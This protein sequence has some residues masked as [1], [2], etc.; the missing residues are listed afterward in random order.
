MVTVLS[1]RPRLCVHRFVRTRV[2]LN[3]V[4]DDRSQNALRAIVRH[5]GETGTDVMLRVMSGRTSS[6]SIARGVLQLEYV[7]IFGKLPSGASVVTYA[8]A[9]AP[10]V[11]RAYQDKYSSAW[12]ESGGGIEDK[13]REGRE[14][15]RRAARILFATKG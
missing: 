15:G 13:R 7:R 9:W 10:D 14:A 3:F 12:R 6:C 5:T 4:L 11:K 8:P 1:R 2:G